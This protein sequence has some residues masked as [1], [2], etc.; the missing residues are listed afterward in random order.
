MKYLTLLSLLLPIALLVSNGAQAYRCN[1]VTETTMVNPP[2]VT[3]QRDQP[4][5]SQIGNQLT[6]STVSTYNCDNSSD[7]PLNYQ[8]FGVKSHGN[9]VTSINGRRVYST[10]IA[11]IGYSVGAIS[12]NNCPGTQGWVDGTHTNDSNPNNYILCSVNGGFHNQPLTARAMITFYKMS[13]TTGSGQVNLG[14]VVSF[15]LKNNQNY[16]MYPESFLN[17]SAF[18][19]TTLACNVDNAAVSVNMGTVEK[20]GFKG[21]GSW[22]GEGNTKNFT[23]PLNCNAGTRVNV[24]IDGPAQDASQGILKLNGAD[25][26][27]GNNTACGIG[28]QLLYNDRPLRLGSS[29][30]TG[31]SESEGSYSISLKARYYQ[32][33]NPVT[34]G[35]ANSNASFT[36]TYH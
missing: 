32:T 28:I 7:P 22:P 31:T 19:V 17:I 1:T 12:D 4:V 10:N 24:Q 9:Y 26:C 36:L 23:I 11:G 3:I 15:I 34:P 27:N 35:D 8:D 13:A 5:G 18:N 20:R 30:L 14:R 16:W 21:V 33:D 2:N 25:N 29:F 6:S